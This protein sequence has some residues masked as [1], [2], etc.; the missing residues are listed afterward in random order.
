MI[1]QVT[2]RLFMIT[3]LIYAHLDFFDVFYFDDSL[4]NVENKTGVNVSGSQSPIKSR[5][6][7]LP[8]FPLTRRLEECDKED[9]ILI[10]GSD[11]VCYYVMKKRRHRVWA[12][13][14]IDGFEILNWSDTRVMKIPTGVDFIPYL[15]HFL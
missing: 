3:S 14:D 1:P 6:F 5:K 2:F 8:T 11:S 10:K 13:E 4:N 9:D 7:A 12:C 15:G